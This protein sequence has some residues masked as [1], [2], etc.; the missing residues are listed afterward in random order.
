MRT[1]ALLLITLYQ[2]FVPTSLRSGCRFHPTCSEYARQAIERH[3]L[4][5]GIG[6]ALHR[7][8][9]CHPLGRHGCDPV[10]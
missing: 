3:G 6:L 8:A 1:A 10:P 4:V 7:L 9:R 5:R 2:R